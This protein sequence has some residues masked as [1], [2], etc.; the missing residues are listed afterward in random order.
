MRRR[1]RKQAKKFF[2]DHQ[3]NCAMSATSLSRLNHSKFVTIHG[4]RFVQGVGK[5]SLGLPMTIGPRD[6]DNASQSYFLRP[7]LRRT[8]TVTQYADYIYTSLLVLPVTVL[9]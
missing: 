5:R 4:M 3:R 9:Q 8:C 2:L 1:D 7:Y 6:E